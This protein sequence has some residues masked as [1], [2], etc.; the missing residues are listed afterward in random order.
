MKPR[1]SNSLEGPDGAANPLTGRFRRAADPELTAPVEAEKIETRYLSPGQVVAASV[2]TALCSV[3][4]SGVM[5]CVWDSALK[6]GGAAHYILPGG[7]G[8]EPGNGRFADTAFEDVMARLLG[9]G[10]HEWNLRARIFGGA[11]I[12]EAFQGRDD[13]LGQRNVDAGRALLERAKVSL[14]ELEIGGRRA[15]R[16]TFRTHDGAFTSHLL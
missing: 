6:V 1:R 7:S 12:V 14:V 15:R 3:V 5:L 13:H 10:C 4:G 8:S 16:V 9:L 2:P 11:C